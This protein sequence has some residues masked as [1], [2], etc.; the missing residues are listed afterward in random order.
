VNGNSKIYKL[1]RLP[2]YLIFHIKRFGRNNWTI[3]K[4]PT[5]VN[6]PL[7]DID[8]REFIDD[9]ILEKNA[10]LDTH[11]NLIVNICHEGKPRQSLA[12]AAAAAGAT[13][14]TGVTIDG[15]LQFGSGKKKQKSADGF[16]KAQVY[17]R[18][19]DQWYQTQDLIVDEIIPQM[20]FL[21]ESYIQV[22]CGAARCAFRCCR[23]SFDSD[24]TISCCLVL[25]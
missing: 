21:G 5:I 20:I 12:G 9:S 2:K 7:K 17:N 11:Y 3:E 25:T 6:F 14:V 16:Y 23:L 8:L 24:L 15:G 10:R 1:L 4:N 22:K 18:G 13:A 19:N